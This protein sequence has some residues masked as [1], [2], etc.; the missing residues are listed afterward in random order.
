MKPDWILVANATHARLLQRERG[1]PMVVLK[2]FEHPQGRTKVSDLSDDRAG[3]GKTDH[4]F[5]GAA[6]PPR[7]D[8]KHKEHTRFAHELIEHLERQAQQG[9]F[10]S[11][12]IFASSPFLGEL[13][14]QLGAATSR[15]LSGTH[16]LDL[17]SFGLNELEQRI[18][19][20]LAR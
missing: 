1:S 13:K 9:S 20:A 6:Y 5:G 11:L 7:V 16:D 18:E 14:A 3:Q 17:T 10:R 19:R 4:D 8:S 15:L 2:N 12:A